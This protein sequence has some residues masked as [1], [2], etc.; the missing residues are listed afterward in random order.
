[1]NQ[2][3]TRHCHW[4]PQSYL[5]AFAHDDKQTKIWRFEKPDHG[6]ELKKFESKSIKKVPVRDY[7]Y[8]PRDANGRRDDRFEKRLATELDSQFDH[9]VW[10]TL[11][12]EFVDLSW[13]P[14]R[15]MV[16]LLAATL[17]MRTPQDLAE[18]SQF[19]AAMVDMLSNFED[20]SVILTICDHE[21]QIDWKEF[22]AYRSWS[23]D[24]LKRNWISE[25]AQ[26]GA[27]A[28][29]FKSMRWSVLRSETP[30]FITS[31]N[32]VTVLHP[33]LEFR[34]LN[35]P[36]TTVRFPISPTHVLHFD[37]RHSEPAN[38]YYPYPK[39]ATLNMLMWRNS[40]EHAF[41][42]RHPEVV[43]GEMLTESKQLRSSKI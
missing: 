42:H 40:I 14:L 7:L 8:V 31:N 23:E 18:R 19:H 11:Q 39:P 6:I 2:K 22:S 10:K 12:T 13:E 35:D 15:M 17:W 29:D 33:S 5:K 21:Q 24:D 36:R 25:I 41:S 30:A 32:P 34:G 3:P 4:V 9:P 26:A 1:M 37:H 38:Q 20:E 43:V 16:A 27:I 28:D